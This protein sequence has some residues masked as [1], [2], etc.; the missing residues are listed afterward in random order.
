MA[1]PAQIHPKL[2]PA[3]F[4]C[5]KVMIYQMA[6]HAQYKKININLGTRKARQ[7][8]RELRSA[9]LRLT[10]TVAVVLSRSLNPRSAGGIEPKELAM[11]VM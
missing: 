7:T 9:L 3:R 2:S 6:K 4:S 5:K 8:P 1:S 10:T 11:L